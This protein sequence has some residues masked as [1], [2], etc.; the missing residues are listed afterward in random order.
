MY[1][2]HKSTDNSDMMISNFLLVFLFIIYRFKENGLNTSLLIYEKKN[3]LFLQR[4][5]ESMNQAEEF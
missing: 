2:L 4:R 3:Y 1:F 5:T